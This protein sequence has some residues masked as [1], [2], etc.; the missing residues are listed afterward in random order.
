[1]VQPPPPWPKRPM[2]DGDKTISATPK[3]SSTAGSERTQ[4][5]HSLFNSMYSPIHSMQGTPDLQ[6]PSANRKG[7]N[8][9]GKARV[10]DLCRQ[11]LRDKAGVGEAA[12]GGGASVPLDTADSYHHDIMDLPNVPQT[13]SSSAKARKSRPPVLDRV[14]GMSLA[15]QKSKSDPSALDAGWG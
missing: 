7:G 6:H 8:E 2:L 13:V 14:P 4:H 10:Q 9:G 5:V 3:R 12:E 11:N 1:M 15:A